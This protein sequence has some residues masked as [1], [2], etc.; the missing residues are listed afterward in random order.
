MHIRRLGALSVIV[1]TLVMPRVAAA[2]DAPEGPARAGWI[3][4]DNQDA[5]RA[6]S[7]FRQALEMNPSDP[8]SL[9][10]SG[11][12][13]LMLG[14]TDEARRAVQKSL[15]IDPSLTYGAV[16]LGQI[17]YR[18]GDL[19]GAIGAYERALKNAPD[20]RDI[21]QQ[22]EQWKKEAALHESFSVR[23]TLR[24]S[25]MFEG[26]E[27]RAVADR[28]SVLLESAYWRIG[29]QLNTY[30]PETITVILYSRK[31]FGDITRSPA[32]ADGAYDGRI[33]L[34]VH[35]ALQSP[36]EL[37]RVATHEFVHAVVHTLAPRGVP[38]WLGEGLATNYES[39]DQ[40]WIMR[41]IR[42]APQLI[43]LDQL[44]SGFEGFTG[45]TAALA[46]A[47]SALAVRI[48]SEQLG[49]NMPVF[50][51]MVGNGQSVDQALLVFNV[52]LE[53]VQTEF[54]RRARGRQAAAKAVGS[55]Q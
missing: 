5:E 29:K 51:Q 4:I 36:G 38:T 26:P 12:A 53:Q 32:W 21:R 19:D 25:V 33:R 45:R 35:G 50:L 42:A 7:A 46:Y 30:P 1:V 27:E 34:P 15:Q 22:L 24:F 11:I 2:Q 13:A 41:W 37:E 40:R 9:L 10:G 44:E 48:I 31:Q 39:A 49:A 14:R 16:V 8:V 43:P 23:P 52:S 6:A 55:R 47:E 20:N 3:A 28:I 17:A 18:E 54:D